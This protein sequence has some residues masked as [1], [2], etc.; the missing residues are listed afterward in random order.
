M[1]KNEKNL[2][3]EKKI[4]KKSFGFGKKK[5]APIP[6]LK[7]DL[8]SVPDTKTWFRSHTSVHKYTH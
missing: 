1:G 5:S 6:I 4:E 7:L 3:L 2:K 8:V